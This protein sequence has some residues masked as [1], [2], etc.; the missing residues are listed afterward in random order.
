M[1]E[2]NKRSMK[3]I[4]MSTHEVGHTIT[5]MERIK[6]FIDRNGLKGTFT[7]LLTV[8]IAAVVGY[9]I[10]N[11][12]VFFEKFEEFSATKHEEA[13]KARMEVDPEIRA[14]LADMKV[15]LN[16]NRTYVLEAHN[17]GTNLSNLPFLY[18][19]LTYIVPRAPY[20]EL[21]SEY[22]NFRLSRFPWATHVADNGFWF[23]PI[24]DVY[25]EDP[26]LY[27][28]LQKEGVKY[29]G[30]ILLHGNN[31]LPIGALGVVYTE[32]E[33]PNAKFVAKCMQKYGSTI[34]ML[35]INDTPKK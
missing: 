25:E 28:K 18:T 6:K 22:K 19:D 21:E 34:S 24:E 33:V 30:M 5:F 23:G 15:E 13:I 2:Q 16:A 27:Y 31:T 4:K 3:D 26:E 35:L 9:F 14:F 29:M 32:E 20:S 11:P 8:F 17:G 10:Y 12:G 7:T 1:E